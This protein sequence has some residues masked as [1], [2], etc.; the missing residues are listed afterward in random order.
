MYLDEDD[1]TSEEIYI[2]M[3]MMISEKRNKH[4]L[5]MNTYGG[6]VGAVVVQ[7]KNTTTRD[8]RVG[9]RKKKTIQD[10]ECR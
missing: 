7:K 1:H 4:A 10:G 5:R 8:S 3:K 2:M 9:I 6:I